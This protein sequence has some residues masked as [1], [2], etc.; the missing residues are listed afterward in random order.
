[1]YFIKAQHLNWSE[2]NSV[3]EKRKVFMWFVIDA[4]PNLFSHWAEGIW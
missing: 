4:I 3:Q 2:E 1:M